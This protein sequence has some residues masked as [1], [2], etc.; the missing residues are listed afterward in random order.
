MKMI[1]FLERRQQFLPR[2][3]SLGILM[4]DVWTLMNVDILISTHVWVGSDQ[5]ESAQ[6]TFWMLILQLLKI[7]ITIH[8][9]SILLKMDI[10]LYGV[11]I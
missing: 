11:V 7:P 4:L 1:D 6:T 3:D 8:T 9:M 10:H 2:L 5:E